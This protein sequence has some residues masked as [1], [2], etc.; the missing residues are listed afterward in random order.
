MRSSGVVSRA[1]SRTGGSLDAIDA[2]DAIDALA[3]QE[4]GD[5]GEPEEAGGERGTGADIEAVDKPVSDADD[6]LVK[7]RWSEGFLSLAV[8]TEGGD[9]EEEYVGGVIVMRGT[10]G[11][12]FMGGLPEEGNCTIPNSETFGADCVGVGDNGRVAAFP[13]MGLYGSDNASLCEVLAANGRWEDDDA[14]NEVRDSIECDSDGG[15]N[16]FEG[17][18]LTGLAVLDLLDNESAKLSLTSSSC[19][20]ND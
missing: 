8:R 3:R 14:S 5:M 11:R 17:S 4:S 6:F 10:D 18:G 1:R 20:P 13:N 16:G 9:D 2:I 15:E 19:I 12:C 7:R